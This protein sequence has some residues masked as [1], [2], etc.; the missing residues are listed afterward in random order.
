MVGRRFPQEVKAAV[1]NLKSDKAPGSDGFSISFFQRYWDLLRDDIMAF[2]KEFHLRGWLSKSIGASLI[3]L[4]PK[5][6]VTDRMKDL[7]PIGNIYKILAKV[8]ATGLQKI[9]PS[10]ISP[11]HGVFFPQKTDFRWV[12]VANECIHL[13][14]RDM[15]PGLVCKLDLEKACDM[16]VWD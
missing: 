8:L 14:H 7:K 11:S 9:L 15:L 3:A 10:S 5:K 6:F 4:I 13:R 1:F 12:L 2:M 16:I